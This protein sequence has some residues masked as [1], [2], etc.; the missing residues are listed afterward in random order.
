MLNDAEL[1]FAA[2]NISQSQTNYNT[3]SHKGLQSFYSMPIANHLP[4]G[5]T[6]RTAPELSTSMTSEFVP[7]PPKV[8]VQLELE[9]DNERHG[10]RNDPLKPQL[11][12]VLGAETSTPSRHRSA[13]QPPLLPATKLVP[14]SGDVTPRPM[15]RKQISAA[16][17][18]EKLLLQSSS[19]TPGTVLEPLPPPSAL[20]VTE[21]LLEGP[22]ETKPPT[23]PGKDMVLFRQNYGGDES[24][25]LPYG[26][27]KALTH[28]FHANSRSLDS[29]NPNIIREHLV[30]TAWRTGGQNTAKQIS[31]DLS[32]VTCMHLTPKYI[33]V[34]LQ[35]AKIHVFN[36]D[37]NNQ[38]TLLGHVTGV[39]A[40][41]PWGD[42]LVSGGADRDV[43]VWDMS[44]G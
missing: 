18:H 37:G 19:S 23:G 21:P 14:G 7:E 25:M 26:A 20:S 41:I 38:K 1:S 11:G 22:A 42:T 5:P 3:A 27:S 15:P 4:P 34:A 9:E 29:T 36:T 24:P 16:A 12:L 44:T 33:V 43:R 6:N 10:S 32:I 31:Q 8:D 17:L 2:L 35:N 28:Q 40:L 39:W 30:E 13:S